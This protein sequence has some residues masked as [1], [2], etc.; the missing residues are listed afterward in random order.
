MDPADIIGLVTGLGLYVV[1]I[2]AFLLVFGAVGG[3]LFDVDG[4]DRA[5]YS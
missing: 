5:P 2:A 1:G 3:W 4:H